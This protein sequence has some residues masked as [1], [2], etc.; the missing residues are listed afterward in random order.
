MSRSRHLTPSSEK[1][2]AIGLSEPT[3]PSHS[4]SHRAKHLRGIVAKVTR[5]RNKMIKPMKKNYVHQSQVQNLCQAISDTFQNEVFSLV[6]NTTNSIIKANLRSIVREEMHKE[7]IS[8]K[9]D[10]RSLITTKLATTTPGHIEEFLQRYMQTHVK[11][12]NSSA[13][14]NSFKHTVLC[15]W[16]HDGH[17]DFLTKG[18]KKAKKQRT[19]RGTKYAKGTSSSTQKPQESNAPSSTE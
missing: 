8:V 17:L 16:D 14:P 11:F 15:K 4:S 6:E 13:I 2:P 7:T 19:T 10:F 18:E 5:R 12:E 1:S 3:N 9:D